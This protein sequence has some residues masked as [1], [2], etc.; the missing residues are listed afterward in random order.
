MSMLSG[1]V[2][3]AQ[4]GPKQLRPAPA[5]APDCQWQELQVRHTRSPVANVTPVRCTVPV[6]ESKHWHGLSWGR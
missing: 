6:H 3:S 2:Q 1:A 4:E 5:P